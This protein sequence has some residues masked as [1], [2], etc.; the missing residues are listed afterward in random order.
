MAIKA[1]SGTIISAWAKNKISPFEFFTP[2]L[3]WIAFPFA[4]S[5]TF[6][7]FD[8]KNTVLSVLPPSTTI[9]SLPPGQSIA[10]N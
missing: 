1:V 10:D 7:I 9:N 4:L 6:A 5:T 8:A 2:S 3:S